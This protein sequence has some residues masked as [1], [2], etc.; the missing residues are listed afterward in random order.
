MLYDSVFLEK[1]INIEIPSLAN[2]R[3]F[4]IAHLFIFMTILTN[5]YYGLDDFTID[6]ATNQKKVVGFNFKTNLNTLN[7]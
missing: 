5:I 3:K 4:N 7:L 6:Y 1:E 2:D